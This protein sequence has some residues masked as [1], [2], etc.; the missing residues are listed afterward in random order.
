LALVFLIDT[1]WIRDSK[2]IAI[3]TH[4]GK[5]IGI[6]Q[7]NLHQEQITLAG[8][9]VSPRHRNRGLGSYLVKYILSQTS[10]PIHPIYVI[11]IPGLEKFYDTNG[12][13][14]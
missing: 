8:L 3:S 5:I 7:L 6:V 2:I 11:A 13:S 10:L 14:I 1:L 12:S 4:R 9:Y